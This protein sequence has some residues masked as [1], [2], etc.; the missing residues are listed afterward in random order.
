MTDERKQELFPY[1]AFTYSQQLNSEKYGNT[2]SIEEWANLI[3]E[4]P[5][6]IQTITE[7]A[8]Q[9]SDEDWDNLDK[10]YVQNQNTQAEQQV[11]YAKKGAKLK[12]LMEL[13]KGGKAKKCSCG[14]DM[15]T[16]KEN[17]GKLTSKCSCNCNGGKMKK[18]QEGGSTEVA[19][20]ASSVAKKG[21]KLEKIKKA[22]EGSKLNMKSL[23]KD[24]LDNA[25]KADP[26]VTP[27]Q[28]SLKGEKDITK[29]MDKETL[30][31]LKVKA[32]K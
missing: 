22:K 21:D 32:K 28:K 8:S 20:Q 1:F 30:K 13:K 14:C 23:K 6:D 26:K 10:E 18:H 19:P 4:S 29:V 5:E 2:S 3:Q 11:T 15:I 12:K 24:E 17:G 16:V 25:K 27:M 9:L 31:R 7:A